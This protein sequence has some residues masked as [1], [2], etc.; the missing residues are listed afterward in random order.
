MLIKLFLIFL[1]LFCKNFF[2]F[3]FL[4]HNC[5]YTYSRSFSVN[6]VPRLTIS[7][8]MEK[9]HDIN[10]ELPIR[11]YEADSPE[12]RMMEN[13]LKQKRQS[14]LDHLRAEKMG[15]KVRKRHRGG[16]MDKLFIGRTASATVKYLLLSPIKLTKI[17]R[18]IKKMPVLLALGDLAQRGA[19]R[20][21]I[22]IYKAIKSALFN[23]KRLYGDE[24]LRPR[25]RELSAT[26]GGFIKKPLFRAKGRCDIIR[27]PKA[28]LRVVLSV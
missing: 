26:N 18:Q 25:F 19:N 10:S 28:H 8:K 17:L 21:A 5:S 15:I 13:T 16:R 11:R 3:A 2:C 12:V 6:S 14:Y 7:Q 4:S 24:T 22:A 9:I 1:I 20:Y 27:K 23:A